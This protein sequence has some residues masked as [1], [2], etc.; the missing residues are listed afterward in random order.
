MPLGVR[1]LGTNP[2]KSGK[3]HPGDQGVEVAFAGV[4]FKPGHFLY[5]DQDGI[6]VS[7]TPLH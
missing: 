7:P 3:Q 5:A 2:I 4:T 6:I 1:A